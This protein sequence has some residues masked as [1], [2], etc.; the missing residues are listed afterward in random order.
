MCLILLSYRQYPQYPLIL[1]SNRD[2]F[3]N[4]PTSNAAFWQDNPNVL[5]GRD[6]E[7]NGT[8]LGITRQGRIAMVTN[9]RDLQP[10][11]DDALSRGWLVSNF[12][13]A[14][15]E[16]VSYLKQIS[17]QKFRYRGFNL[18]VGDQQTLGYFSNRSEEVKVLAP[19]LYGLSNHLLD[20]PWPKLVF[21]KTELDHLLSAHSTP[22]TEK[23]FQLLAESTPFP[24]HELPNTGIGLELEQKLSP[25]C[26][27]TP[28]YGTRT[29]TIVILQKGGK[30][31]FLE[32]ARDPQSLQWQE[33]SK[34][35]FQL[36]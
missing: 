18:L 22:P 15:Q 6:L 14:T 3:Y 30:V 27:E 11:P 36:N 28:T 24:D 32:R 16:P 5:A 1:I 2:E 20:T 33:T 25:L 8:W 34:F 7:Q 10:E 12:L 19:G 29:S 23:L 17:Q 4:R 35:C 13:T 21:G 26:I 9:F 31:T